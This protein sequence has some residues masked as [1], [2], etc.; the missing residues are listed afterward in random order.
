[1]CYH[2]LI[3]MINL[4]TKI[5]L[6][7]YLIITASMIYFWSHLNITIFCR[8][9]NLPLQKCVSAETIYK[10]YFAKQ[11]NMF[12]DLKS[13]TT[14]GME[15]FTCF[16]LR[17]L[18]ESKMAFTDFMGRLANDQRVSNCLDWIWVSFKYCS[19]SI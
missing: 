6:F 11:A 1:M 14:V 8:H 9:N 13:R 17:P 16:V 4:W 3:N 7:K 19:L 10:T 12:L 18:L 5:V 15:L 2:F